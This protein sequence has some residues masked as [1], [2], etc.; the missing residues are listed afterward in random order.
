MRFGKVLKVGLRRS[1]FLVLM[2]DGDRVD[3]RCVATL[4][5]VGSRLM[6]FKVVY[7]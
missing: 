5:F 4:F 6:P 3:S 1:S 2:V 7:R